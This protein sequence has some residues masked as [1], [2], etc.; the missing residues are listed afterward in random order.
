[1]D[2]LSYL[3]I[4]QENLSEYKEKL[5]LG[6]DFMFQQDNDPKHKSKIAENFFSEND[7]KVMEWPSQSPDL[8]VIEHVWSY[9][10]QK[11]RENPASSKKEAFE[12]IV[13]IWQEIP[14]DF[15]QKLVDSIHRRLEEVIRMKGGP[16]SY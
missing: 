3:R 9:I 1:M 11:Y 16:T 6:N 7:I 12:K 10:K 4:L 13:K 2:G 14:I 8:N 5:G 15:I